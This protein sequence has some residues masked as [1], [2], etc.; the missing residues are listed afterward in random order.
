[1]I[2]FT[3]LK[4]RNILSTGNAWTEISLNTHDS[5]LIVGQNGSGKSTMLDAICFALYGKPFRNVRKPQ[6]VNSINNAGLEVHI[7]FTSGTKSY[8]IKRGIKPAL[9]EIWCDGSMLN[10]DASSRDYQIYLEENILKMN[11]KSFGQIVVLGSSTFVPFMQ[12]PSAARR[13]V[14]EDLLDLQIFTTMNILLKDKID[15][16]KDATKTAKYDFDLLTNRIK[17]SKTHSDAIKNLKEDVV[18]GIKKDMITEIDT[19]ELTDKAIKEINNKIDHVG[20]DVKEFDKIREWQAAEKNIASRCLSDQRSLKREL[21]F[22]KEHAECPT[23]SQDIDTSLKAMKCLEAEEELKKL[24]KLYV[25]TEENLAQLDDRHSDLKL[26][27]N[28]IQKLNMDIGTHKHTII[29]SKNNLRALKRRLDAA[30]KDAEDVNTVEAANLDKELAL[31]HEAQETLSNER[32][33]LAVTGVM[34]RDAGIKARIIKQYVPV[35]NKLINKYLAEMDFFVQFELDESFNETIKSRYRDIFS[36]ASFSEGEKLRIDLCLMLTWR[37]VARLRSSVSTNLLV[38][39]EVFDGSL[40][41]DGIEALTSILTSKSENSNIFIIS[42]KGDKIQD[43]F[44]RVLV[45]KKT[46]NFSVISEE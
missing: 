10:Q 34:L 18:S 5:T 35:I 32:E 25:S 13:A 1:M 16:N 46:K 38:L 31:A 33:M 19:I 30:Q 14:I 21:K 11:F 23:C 7:A 43:K 39:D 22:F 3:T 2:K 6:L 9:F 27:D 17:Q 24:Y 44:D 8:T 12:L 26:V 45:A 28:F 41:N 36:Y 40:D 29:F 20:L 15:V 37:S 4:Y 42:H